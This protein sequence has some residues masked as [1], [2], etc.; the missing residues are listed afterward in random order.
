MARYC[1]RYSAENAAMRSGSPWRSMQ[2][3]PL[4][5]PS[6]TGNSTL[7]PGAETETAGYCRNIATRPLMLRTRPVH[8]SAAGRFSG[9]SGGPTGLSVD[10][11]RKVVRTSQP[12]F[13]QANGSTI[14]AGERSSGSACSST[15]R[16]RDRSSCSPPHLGHRPLIRFSSPSTPAWFKIFQVTGSAS[17]VGNQPGPTTKARREPS[18]RRHVP[19]FRAGIRHRPARSPCLCRQPRQLHGSQAAAQ[20]PHPRPARF[21]RPRDAAVSRRPAPS[22]SAARR[23]EVSALRWADVVP[24]VPIICETTSLMRLV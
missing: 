13:A 17:P 6:W 8:I 1:F 16:G 12:Q 19:G 11:Y 22:D 14:S 20:R 21:R 24:P 5:L 10:T 2:R 7:L 15:R 18:Q 23:S 4:N 9:V 3:P